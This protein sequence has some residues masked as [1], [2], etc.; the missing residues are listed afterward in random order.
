MD[1]VGRGYDL[2]QKEGVPVA[3]TLGRHSN[4]HMF[5]F[6]MVTPSGFQTEYGWGGRLVSE[7]W[8]PFELT[9]G[10]SLWGHAGLG[11]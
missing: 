11:G 3:A 5:S 7:S 1:D 2:V 4:D 9:A 6:Y 10:P 8:E